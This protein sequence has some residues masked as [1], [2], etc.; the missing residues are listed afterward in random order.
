MRAKGWAPT[1]DDKRIIMSD[2]TSRLRFLDPETLKETGGITVT[3]EGQCW[4]TS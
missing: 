4:W 3:D 2:G 1:R